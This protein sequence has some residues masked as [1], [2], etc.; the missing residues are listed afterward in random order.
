MLRYR[1]VSLHYRYRGFLFGAF[2]DLDVNDDLISA[3]GKGQYL[4]N[5]RAQGKQHSLTLDTPSFNFLSGTWQAPISLTL[6]KDLN[7]QGQLYEPLLFLGLPVLTEQET[8]TLDSG[9]LAG[10][11]LHGRWQS[12]F[13]QT[14]LLASQIIPLQIDMDNS[15]SDNMENNNSNVSDSNTK[16]AGLLWPGFSVTLQ[17]STSF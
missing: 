5:L 12:G 7:V 10:I 11:Q 4:V 8:Q 6:L 15:E 14:H 17:L 16:K 13:W 2:S 9:T 1:D 3:V